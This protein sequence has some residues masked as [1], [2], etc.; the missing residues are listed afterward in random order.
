MFHII[1]DPPF[2]KKMFSETGTWVWVWLLVRIYIGYEWLTAGWHKVGDPAWMD[3]GMALKGFWEK[4]VAIP[5]S[6][7][8]PSISFDWYRGFLEALLSGGHYI[9]FAKLVAF[10]EILV[11]VAL[12]IGAFVGIAAFFGAL[13][14]FN[15]MLAGTASTNPVLFLMAILLMLAWKNAGHWGLD[16]WLL[17]RLGTPWD[18]NNPPLR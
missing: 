1:T 8:R 9:W 17:P 5:V 7:A 16:R 11:G 13:M 10:G 12:I 3:G 2:A 18:R 14:N 15:F 4:A 6:P